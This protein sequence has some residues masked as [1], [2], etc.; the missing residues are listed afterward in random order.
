MNSRCAVGPRSN[1]AGYHEIEVTVKWDGLKVRARPGYYIA[2]RG[3]LR[4]GCF[5]VAR[6]GHSDGPAV[7]MTHYQRVWARR[8]TSNFE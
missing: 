3:E 6:D 8:A 2:G 4:L 5:R 7:V 1:E